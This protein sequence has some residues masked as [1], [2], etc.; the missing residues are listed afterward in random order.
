MAEIRA[1]PTHS[2]TVS[3]RSRGA[4]AKRFARRRRKR[5]ASFDTSACRFDIIAITGSRVEWL[6]DAFGA[7]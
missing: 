3:G 4:Q 5:D 7:P 2:G 1:G 6:K